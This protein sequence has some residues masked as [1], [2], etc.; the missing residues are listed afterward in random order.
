M[1]KK[2][3][4]PSHSKRYLEMAG[5]VDKA[6]AYSLEE[7]VKIVKETAKTKFDSSVEVH[8]HLGIDTQK[9]EQAV[10]GVAALPHGTGKTKKVAVFIRNEKIAKDAGADLVGADELIKQI[11]TTEKIDFDVALAT[12]EMMKDMAPIAKVLGPKGLMPAP[13]SG[14]VVPEAEIAKAIEEIKKG[15]VNFRNDDTGNIHQIIGK[16]SW[17]ENKLLENLKVFIEALQKAKPAAVKGI[18]IVNA[19]LT[20]KIDRRLGGSTTSSDRTKFLSGLSNRISKIQ[21]VRFWYVT[22]VKPK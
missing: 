14:T 13:K 17:D 15:K 16:A 21:G 18:F 7:A 20:S 11:K 5:K 6:K 3:K 2:T 22:V 12:P 19:T 1:K 10:R 9:G 4:K 8:V